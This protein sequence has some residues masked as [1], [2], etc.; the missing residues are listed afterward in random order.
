MTDRAVDVIIMFFVV[1]TIIFLAAQIVR[2]VI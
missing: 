2:W 1:V